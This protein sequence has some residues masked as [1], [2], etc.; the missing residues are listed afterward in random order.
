M[1]EK[2][3]SKHFLLAYEFDIMDKSKKVLGCVELKKFLSERVIG[4]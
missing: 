3:Q 1:E 2:K 4:I